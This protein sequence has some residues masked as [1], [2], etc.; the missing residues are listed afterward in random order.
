VSLASLL[1][2]AEDV[3]Y[4]VGTSFKVVLVMPL[5]MIGLT[6]WMTYH[7]ARLLPDNRYSFLGRIYYVLITLVS[8]AT[9]WQLYHWNFLGF[10]Y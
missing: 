10:N 8:L 7:A 9:L 4:G 1:S 5:M 3:V 2:D 6:S